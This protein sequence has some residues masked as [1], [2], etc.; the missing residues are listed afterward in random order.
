MYNSS[1]RSAMKETLESFLTRA[2]KAQKLDVP[3][4]DHFCKQVILPPLPM[5]N[6]PIPVGVFAIRPIV[7]VTVTFQGCD[8]FS[9]VLPET[10]ASRQAFW[11]NIFE[12]V[13]RFTGDGAPLERPVTESGHFLIQGDLKKYGFVNCLF[14]LEGSTLHVFTSSQ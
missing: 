1:K 7:D 8:D 10:P 2:L 11:V 9:L 12:L 5:I 3:K 6:T 13:T 4:F 14:N